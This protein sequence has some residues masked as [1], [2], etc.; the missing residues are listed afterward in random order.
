MEVVA[1][2]KRFSVVV[3]IFCV[4]LAFQLELGYAKPLSA[5]R[6]A[7]VKLETG[8]PD[9]DQRLIMINDR[10]Q[11]NMDM[12][13]ESMAKHFGVTQ[14]LVRDLLEKK[15]S[16]ADIYMTV[17]ISKVTKQDTNKILNTY[18]A[19]RGKS[20]GAIAQELGIKPG[21]KE[22]HAL[23]EDNFWSKEHKQKSKE[24]KGKGKGS[25]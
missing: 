14:S 5:A 3:L 4:V 17:L 7:E 24:P 13:V 20:W 11:D 16:P 23:K 22:F 21:S 8:D 6:K 18:N 10:A 9:L 15:L 1:M 12:F 19:N 25:Q 2:V